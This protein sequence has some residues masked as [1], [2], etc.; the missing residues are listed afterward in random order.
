MKKRILALMLAV[1]MLLTL[2]GCAH[3]SA[4]ITINKDGTS[5]VEKTIGVLR[6]ICEDTAVAY[7]EEK[8]LE[9]DDLF[10][11]LTAYIS[12]AR[13]G[14]SVSNMR[15][16]TENLRTYIVADVSSD[17]D[18]KELPRL[19]EGTGHIIRGDNSFLMHVYRESVNKPCFGLLTAEEEAYF[20]AEDVEYIADSLVVKYAFDFPYPVQQAKGSSAGITI[21]GNHLEIDF[22]ALAPNLDDYVFYIGNAKEAESLYICNKDP[23]DNFADVYGT[24]WYAPATSWAKGKGVFAG[25][26]YGFFYPKQSVTNAM[27]AQVLFNMETKEKQDTYQTE[28]SDLW[29]ARAAEYCMEND[30]F[31]G[32]LDL[33]KDS[34]AQY[35]QARA[36]QHPVTGESMGAKT[37]SAIAD[38][39][40][41]QPVSREKAVAA[42][43]KQFANLGLLTD[44]S[45]ESPN[46]PDID[47]V[48]PQYRGLILM[49][50][51]YGLTSGVNEE[52]YFNPQIEL[53]RAGLCQMLFNLRVQFMRAIRE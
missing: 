35:K 40:W 8:G 9:S 26:Q 48:S 11:I 33:D 17:L 7:K 29:Y 25:D 13:P 1:S 20:S 50:Y 45:V 15:E 19:M 42:V 39:R 31:Y 38:V 14:V 6:S 52:G 28:E 46:I 27:L 36:E 2:A 3:S 23:E 21:N 10:E 32:P 43:M 37:A 18:A 24:E 12:E 51:T 16:I 53:S 49:A 47:K 22:N 41:N 30:L 5:R 4:N 34:Y 44:T